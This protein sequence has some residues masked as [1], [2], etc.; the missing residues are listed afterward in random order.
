MMRTL[1]LRITLGGSIA[2]VI[3]SGCASTTNDNDHETHWISCEHSAA[4]P[5]GLACQNSVCVDGNGNPVSRTEGC[6]PIQLTNPTGECR[7][8]NNGARAGYHAPGC[9]TWL[10]DCANPHSREYWRVFAKSATS[11]YVIPRPDGARE[12][13][14]PCNLQS[15]P[16]RALVDKYRLCEQATTPESV[17]V[18]NDMMPSEAL[19]ITHFMHALLLFEATEGIPNVS[20]LPFPIPSDVLDA[21]N[22]HVGQNSPALQ[23]DCDAVRQFVASGIEPAPTFDETAGELALLLNELYGIAGCVAPEIAGKVCTS[24]GVVGGC[25]SAEI[26]C[27]IPCTT[28]ADCAGSAAGAYC[29]MGVCGPVS[30][31]L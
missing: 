3:A 9:D 20:L 25:G 18:V 26:R 11:A 1:L 28:E 19:E 13:T 8:P 5:M 22:L 27:T 17:D 6:S 2:A 29:M 15:H 7:A 10:P 30:F 4:C 14:A 23:G 12:L 24:C 16:M 21:C 31:C